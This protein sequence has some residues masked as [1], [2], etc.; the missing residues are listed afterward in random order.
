MTFTRVRLHFGNRRLNLN[1]V[2]WQIWNHRPQYN[3]GV[4]T[5]SRGTVYMDST[6][7]HTRQNMDKTDY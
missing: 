1:V 7:Q 4:S 6:T 5:I 2:E 3:P